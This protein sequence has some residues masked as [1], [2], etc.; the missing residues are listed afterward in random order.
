MSQ[1]NDLLGMPHGTAGSRLRKL[2]LFDFARKLGVDQCFRCGQRIEDVDDLS[3]E[4][5]EPWQSA[6]DPKAAFFDLGNIA[7]SHLRCNSAEGNRAN[8]AKEQCPQGH[9]YFGDNLIIESRGGGKTQ[10]ACRECRR[11]SSRAYYRAHPRS[12]ADRVPAS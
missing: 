1:K 6:P 3:V 12:S 4:H 8:R 11:R 5:K 2:I 10:R 9:P 7:F